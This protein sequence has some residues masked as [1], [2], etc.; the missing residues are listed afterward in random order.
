MRDQ[1]SILKRKGLLHG[2]EGQMHAKIQQR[3]FQAGG[4]LAYPRKAKSELLRQSEWEGR[5]SRLRSGR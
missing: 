4:S 2:S 3:A 5:W 1:A